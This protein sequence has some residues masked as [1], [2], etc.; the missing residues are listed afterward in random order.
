MGYYADILVPDNDLNA[1]LDKLGRLVGPLYAEAWNKNKRKHYGDKPFDLNINAF[2]AMWFDGALKI[3]VLYDDSN[4]DPVGFLTGAVFRPMPYKATVFQIQEWYVKDNT[5]PEQQ[6]ID[7]TMQSIRILGC[8]EV[9]VHDTDRRPDMSKCGWKQDGEF[10][11]L[12]F[13]KG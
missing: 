3:F 2:A 1:S 5:G 9:W 7:Y 4:N 13:I 10:V 11:G 12:R 6:L 8:D